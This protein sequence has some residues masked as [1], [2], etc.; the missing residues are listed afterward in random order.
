VIGYCVWLL[1]QDAGKQLKGESK[2]E[3]PGCWKQMK[4]LE[5]GAERRL[6]AIRVGSLIGSRRWN[7][8][9]H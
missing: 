2:K 5:Q 6:G 8:G 7:Q 3:G 9:S 1:V 4:S